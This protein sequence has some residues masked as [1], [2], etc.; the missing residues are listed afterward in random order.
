MQGSHSR[1]QVKRDLTN[2]KTELNEFKIVSF[3]VRG[4]NSEA[5]QKV[6]YDH[7]KHKLL[8]LL[9]LDGFWSYQNMHQCNE[10]CWNASRT[11]N[12]RLQLMNALETYLFWT[13]LSLG[14][15]RLQVLSCYLQSGEQQNLKERAKRDTNI[16]RAFIILC[17][18]DNHINFIV[19]QLGPVNFSAALEPGTKIH[20]FCD[21]L[22]QAI[23]RNMKIREVTMIPRYTDEISD[24]RCIK[25]SLRLLYY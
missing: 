3:N 13:Q 16:Y 7:V 11:G 25:V 17:S 23:A 5:K 14:S 2:V 24:H 19:E 10:R 6:V 22:D 15:N 8:S 18:N 4:L 20:H 9:Y 12:I 21:H 1:L